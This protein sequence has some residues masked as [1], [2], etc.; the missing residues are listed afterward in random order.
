MITW[1]EV[2][3]FQLVCDTVWNV[4]FCG[5]A[6]RSRSELAIYFPPAGAKFVEMAARYVSINK[7][8][9]VGW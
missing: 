8:E 2:A 9:C 5:V 7:H 1:G 4:I 6:A 3:H